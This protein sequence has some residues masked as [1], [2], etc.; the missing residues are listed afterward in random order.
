MNDAELGAERAMPDPER[1]G[2]SLVTADEATLVREMVTILSAFG[3]YSPAQIAKVVGRPEEEIL[4]VREEPEVQEAMLTLRSLLPRPG[5]VNELLMSDAERNIRWLRN[6]REGR[7]DGGVLG[8]DSKTLLVRAR[9]AQL[10]L[11]RQVARKVE[12]TA[13]ELRV[14]DLTDVQRAR[15]RKLLDVPVAA[16]AKGDGRA[17]TDADLDRG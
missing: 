17:L 1:P 15:M 8:I 16:E 9:A 2:E 3:R 11:D 7:V 5:D 10:L 6:L 12:I 13:K 4:T 14:I